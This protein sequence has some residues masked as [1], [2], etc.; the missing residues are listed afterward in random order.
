MKPADPK[1]EL[2]RLQA[3]NQALEEETTRLQAQAEALR[4]EMARLQ[5]QLRVGDRAVG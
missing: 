2:A 1:V 4:E 5:A 3:R